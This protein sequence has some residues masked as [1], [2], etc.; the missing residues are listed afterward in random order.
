MNNKATSLDQQW[1]AIREEESFSAEVGPD[2]MD[3][4]VSW[5]AADEFVQKLIEQNNRMR[6][7]LQNVAAYCENQAIYDKL[8]RY[9]DFYYK[10]KTI[11]GEE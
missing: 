5:E 2:T 1:D 6:S 7:V 9:G 11:L 3:L 4:V 10:A 8:S